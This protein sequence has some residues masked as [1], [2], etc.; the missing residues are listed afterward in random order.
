M[1]IVN[2]YTSPARKADLIV[3]DVLTG[4]LE[5]VLEDREQVRIGIC[6]VQLL[7]DQLKHLASALSVH[8]GLLNERKTYNH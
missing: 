7:L 1:D 6:V 8:V 2:K 4:H 5:A 3:M